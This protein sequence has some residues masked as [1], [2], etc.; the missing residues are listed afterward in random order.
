M[1]RQLLIMNETDIQTGKVSTYTS[2]APLPR[3]D[4]YSIETKKIKQRGGIYNS[5]FRKWIQLKRGGKEVLQEVVVTRNVSEADSD[6]SQARL[7]LVVMY[8]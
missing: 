8:P 6:S 4:V 2:H 3:L 1:P 5:L 7:G